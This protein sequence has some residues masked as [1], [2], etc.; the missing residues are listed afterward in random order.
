MTQLSIAADLTY[1]QVVNWTTNVRKRNLKATVEQGK[2]PHHFIDFLFLADDREKRTIAPGNTAT[3]EPKTPA[4]SSRRKPR[5]AA[6][7]KGT[8][9]GAKGKKML[10]SMNSYDSDNSAAAVSAVSAASSASIMTP[11]SNVDPYPEPFN[12]STLFPSGQYPQFQP[13]F[14]PPQVVTP[15]RFNPNQYPSYG[16]L[17]ELAPIGMSLDWPGMDLTIATQPISGWTTVDDTAMLRELTQDGLVST[18]TRRDS[19]ESIDDNQLM[20]QLA[21]VFRDR[22]EE[23]ERDHDFLSTSISIEE[24]DD[25]MAIDDND[26][27]DLLGEDLVNDLRMD[28]EDLMNDFIEI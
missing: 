24:L 7:K 19:D 17:P 15:P 21:N 10:T 2:K 25:M 13:G 1:A 18:P 8:K 22:E 27:M 5:T 12:F 14:V 28:E 4:S 16:E 6:P 3:Y 23:M 20:A 11:L 26:V 9:K